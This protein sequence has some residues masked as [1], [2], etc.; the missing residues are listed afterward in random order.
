MRYC[1]RCGFPRPPSE[2][3]CPKCSGCEYSQTPNEQ[4][5]AKAWVKFCKALEKSKQTLMF[6]RDRYGRIL[7]DILFIGGPEHGTVQRFPIFP[8]Y[9]TDAA[10][11]KYAVAE[12]G[13]TPFCFAYDSDF[14]Q[15][16]AAEVFLRFLVT[17]EPGFMFAKHSD[18]SVHIVADYHLGKKDN[19]P[20]LCSA[21]M[22]PGNAL[23]QFTGAA[24]TTNCCPQ[25]L[26]QL[27]YNRHRAEAN[28]Q[29]RKEESP[30]VEPYKTTKYERRK[31][32]PE[33]LEGQKELF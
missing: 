27:N 1:N 9:K 4:T 6:D 33:S 30:V 29:K 5:K 24:T 15:R 2:G 26:Y 20:A 10:T 7:Y 32:Q 21:N 17:T 31:I 12:V 23:T 25:C 11:Y 18:G 19:V 14:G 3:R 16:A 22:G 28:S 13:G 8:Y